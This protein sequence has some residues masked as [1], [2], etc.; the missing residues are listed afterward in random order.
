MRVPFAALAFSVLI[1][2]AIAAAQ[3]PE[4]APPAIEPP[5]AALPADPDASLNPADAP[6]GAYQLDPRHAS[7]IWRIRHTGLGLVVGRFDT[8]AGTLNFDPAAPIN[9]NVDVT[10]QTASVTTGIRERDGTI[11]FDGEI[12][13]VLGAD[14]SPQIHFVSRAATLTGPNTGLVQGDLTLNGQTHPATLEVTFQGGRFVALRGKYTLGFSARTII[15]R[16]QWDVE[17]LIFNQFAGDMVEIL[18]EGEW[19]KS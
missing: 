13:D 17:N 10:I 6:A 9:S 7:V 19:V 12:A 3:T 15:D 2:G 11:K 14:N 1:S 18:I 5:L 8:I 4:A 16:K